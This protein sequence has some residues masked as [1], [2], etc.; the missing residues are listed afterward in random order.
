M[1]INISVLVKKYSVPALF[2]LFGTFMLV[3]GIKQNQDNMFLLA[4]VLMFLAGII[5]IL[6]S[7]GK[8]KISI[9]YGISIFAGIAA[10]LLLFFSWKS[11]DETNTYNKNYAMCKSESIQNLTDIR[12]AQKAY[13]E[14]YGTYAKDWATLVE[15]INTGT[16]PFVESVGVVPSRK[17]TVEESKYI[18][19]DNRPIDVNMTEKE[20]YLLSKSPLIP[21]DLVG[22]KRDTIQI[23]LL[24][25][26]FLTRANIENRKKTGLPMFNAA[27]LRFIPFTKNTKEWKLETKDSIQMGDDFFPAIMVSGDMPF[28]KIQGTA[29]E[30]I[31]FGK[32][33][34]NE[35]AGSWED[36]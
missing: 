20:A 1:E 13:A 18:Y 26:K 33:T 15:F 14:K 10:A 22:F 12:Y 2:F 23:S 35:T 36:E 30:K 5:S 7:T 32:L 6:Y 34:S 4:A 17:M 24:N 29:N 8:L 31:S 19:K 28:A 21:E 11:V 25:S 3:T 16:V 27:N 9:I